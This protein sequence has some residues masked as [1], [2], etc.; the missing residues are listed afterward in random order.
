[1]SLPSFL[2]LNVATATGLAGVLATLT[3]FTLLTGYAATAVCFLI[4][5]FLGTTYAV[6]AT[7]C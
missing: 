5:T 4:S 7:F 3:S 1:M 6:A 2:L